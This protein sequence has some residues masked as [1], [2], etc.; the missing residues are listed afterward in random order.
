MIDLPLRCR[1]A[2]SPENPYQVWT[3]RC[4]ADPRNG[5]DDGL[6][7]LAHNAAGAGKGRYDAVHP[8]QEGVDEQ[9]I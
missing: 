1:R 2:L 9:Y 3:S 6:T 4:S 8:S 7:F 5:R